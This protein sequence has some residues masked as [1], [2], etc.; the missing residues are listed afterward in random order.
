MFR[1]EQYFRQ[2]FVLRGIPMS[3]IRLV[4]AALV[5]ATVMLAAP[6]AAADYG[7]FGVFG[8]PNGGGFEEGDEIPVQF[9]AVG[10]DCDS[11]SVTQDDTG[12]APSGGPGGDTFSFTVSP[13]EGTYSITAECNSSDSPNVAPAAQAGVATVEQA[14][15]VQGAG[16]N[17]DTIT[18]TVREEGDDDDDDGNGNGNGSSSGA[19]PDTGGENRGPLA[20]GAGLVLVGTGTI[21]VARRRWAS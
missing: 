13:D 20:I 11:W 17:E 12:E 6:A 3:T 14:S 5:A 9:E 4:F 2:L 7:P 1:F 8:A 19:L 21:V 15:F 16:E 18:F 10:I